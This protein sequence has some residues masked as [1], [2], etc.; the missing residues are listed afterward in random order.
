MAQDVASVSKGDASVRVSLIEPR[1][2]FGAEVFHFANFLIIDDDQAIVL[3]VP[4]T[5]GQGL[6]I[7]DFRRFVPPCGIHSFVES[8]WRLS[9]RIHIKPRN[10]GAPSMIRDDQRRSMERFYSFKKYRR[11]REVGLVRFPSL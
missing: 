9:D 7:L 5:F 3:V 1:N 10:V 4:F 8:D 11:R 2:V 6:G